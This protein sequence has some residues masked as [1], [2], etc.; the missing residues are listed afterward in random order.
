MFT[1]ARAARHILGFL[2]LGLLAAC[3]GRTG[4]PTTPPLGTSQAAQSLHTLASTTATAPTETLFVYSNYVG[5][6]STVSLYASPSYNTL[7]PTTIGV[8]VVVNALAVDAANDIFV[9]GD[10][11]TQA[12]RPG[13]LQVV[14]VFAPPYTEKPTTIISNPTHIYGLALNAAGDLFVDVNNTITEYAPP[15]TALSTPIA[16]IPARSGIFAMDAA[17]DIFA[18][19]AAGTAGT[20][21]I[22]KSSPPYTTWTTIVP[23]TGG[24]VGNGVNSLAVD[25]AGNVFV[26]SPNG[27]S[28][29]ITEYSAASSYATPTSI[30][31]TNYG[32]VSLAV[33]G[34]GNIFAENNNT[35]TEYKPPYTTQPTIING[36]A[37]EGGLLAV[38]P[39]V[40]PTACTITS[41]P[42]VTVPGRPNTQTIGI[43]EIVDLTA[44]V[45]VTWAVQ[46]VSGAGSVTQAGFFTAA[47]AAETNTVTATPKNG[48]ASC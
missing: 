46:P 12:P 27:S 43:G 11:T 4:A 22:V 14:Q 26:P 34:A 23:N 7:T 37:F 47:Y 15:F 32:A 33:D 30:G 18:P 29:E 19:G 1:S 3:G 10:S 6:P 13:D 42:I 39:T 31:S 28:T 21:S 17:G 45:P 5:L 16:T 8:N 9:A 41:T 48:S 35:A 38:T 40:P 20:S 36:V 2:A 44:N 24:A 25:A